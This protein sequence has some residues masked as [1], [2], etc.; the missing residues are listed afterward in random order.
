VA[1]MTAKV[2]CEAHNNRLGEAVDAVAALATQTIKESMRLLDTRKKIRSRNYNVL[3]FPIY[4]PH[5]ERWF[6]KTL[7]NFTE[8]DD[9]TIRA[10]KRQ[11]RVAAD[12]LVRIAFGQSSFPG[13]SG[14]WLAARPRGGKQD[15][16]RRLQFRAFNDGDSVVGGLFSFCGFHFY[17]NLEAERP[18]HADFNLRQTIRH[19][20]LFVLQVPDKKNRPVNSHAIEFE[21]PERKPVRNLAFT[22]HRVAQL[23]RR[24][25]GGSG[26]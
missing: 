12:E 2:L 26:S 23:V 19:P 6:L 10:G 1:S 21:W 24:T 5:L 22:S 7:I 18:S 8:L 25:H 20:H 17:L 13:E 16:E 4:G 14:L 9:L 11:N 3:R 15:I